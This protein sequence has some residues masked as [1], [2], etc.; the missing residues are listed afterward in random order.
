MRER[1]DLAD[2]SQIILITVDDT[3][4]PEYLSLWLRE[5]DYER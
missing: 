5:A 2:I 3:L 4:R 1:V